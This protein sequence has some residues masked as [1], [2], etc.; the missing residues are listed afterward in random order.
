M[1]VF[2]YGTYDSETDTYSLPEPHLVGL[3]PKG[4]EHLQNLKDEVR[5]DRWEYTKF[6]IPVVVSIIALIS[7]QIALYFAILCP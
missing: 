2:E 7:S 4:E 1:F 3:S 6:W 5:A